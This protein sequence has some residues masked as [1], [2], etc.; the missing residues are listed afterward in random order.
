MCCHDDRHAE[1]MSAPGK[2]IQHKFAGGG[3]KIA[4]RLIS[5]KQTRAAR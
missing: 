5:Q 2:Q 4:S 1:V 3:V